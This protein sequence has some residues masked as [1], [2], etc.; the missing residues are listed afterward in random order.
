TQGD[1]I[2]TIT[3]SGMGGKL[4]SEILS[5]TEHLFAVDTLILQPNMGA[6][7]IREWLQSHKF[8]IT[9]ETI[10]YENEKFYEIIVGK[11]QASVEPLTALELQFGPCLLLSKSEVFQ[12]F[13]QQEISKRIYQIEQMQASKSQAALE[14]AAIMQA[15]IMV[16]TEVLHG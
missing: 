8:A 6:H 13:W 16:I 4:I 10:V 15:E 2:Q 12:A 1:C 3:I 5:D 14:K 9:D 7:F 11:K